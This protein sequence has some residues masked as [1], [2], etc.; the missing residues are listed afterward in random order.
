MKTKEELKIIKEEVAALKNKLVEL[1]DEELS[2]VVGGAGYSY[3][4]Y[5]DDSR[6]EKCPYSAAYQLWD[7]HSCPSCSK[8]TVDFSSGTE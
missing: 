8:H 3:C 2:Q 6:I 1:N 4:N 5:R 7:F